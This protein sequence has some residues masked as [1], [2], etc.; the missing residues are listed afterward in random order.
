MIRPSDIGQGLIVARRARGLSQRALAGLLGVKQQQVARWES[1]AYASASLRRVGRV[2]EV[3]G[4][5]AY[6]V[7]RVDLSVQEPRAAY[8]PVRAGAD[9]VD[10][11]GRV[12]PARD[13][14]EVIVR[15]REHEERLGRR[16]GVRSIDVF[17]S[18]ARGEQ[19]EASDI[20]LVV[21]VDEPSLRTV[22]GAEEY[23]ERI[24]GRKV[25]AGSLDSLDETARRR[26]VRERVRA[27]PA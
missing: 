3:L 27:W 7:E 9:D 14:G 20:D 2:A 22:F 12:S 19:T 13:L 6:E 25:D 11:R 24:L 1:D 18:F 10:L 23:L 15:L 17:G 26:A 5:D 21:E 8:A 16:F 4:L